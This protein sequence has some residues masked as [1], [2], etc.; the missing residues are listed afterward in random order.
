MKYHA[1]IVAVALLSA[2]PILNSSLAQVVGRT[3][4]AITAG[5]GREAAP[6]TPIDPVF[7]GESILIP[8]KHQRQEMQQC[9]PTSA[10][11]MLEKVGLNYP[12]RQIK[13]AT[14][15]KPYYGPST[16]FNYYT[17]TSFS[18]LPPS[19][20]YLNIFSW[21]CATYRSTELSNGLIDIK[22][23]IRKNYPVMMCITE[24][25]GYG[26][27][28]VICGFDDK[29]LRLIASDPAIDSPGI[30]Y[31]SYA[32]IDKIWNNRFCGNSNR[33]LIFMF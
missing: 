2:I 31:I 28:L 13:L 17:P 1:K 6:K 8:I 30:R 12:P 22:N 24:E 10:S 4:L 14:L 18:G 23:S 7:L 20:K 15:G 27:A 32:N 21:R 19:L 3:P 11:M 9:V 25:A 26:H 16:P 5:N 33:M 29:N